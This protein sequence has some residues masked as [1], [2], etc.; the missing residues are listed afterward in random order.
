[1]TRVLAAVAAALVIFAVGI[2]L[3]RALEDNPTPNLTV[4]TT[5]TLIP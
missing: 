5:K 4:T 2:A 3:G 1:V